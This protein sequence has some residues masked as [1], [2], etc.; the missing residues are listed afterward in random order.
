[1]N[2]KPVSIPVVLQ[3]GFRPFF[4]AAGIYAVIAMLAWMLFY[5]QPGSLGFL[6]YSPLHWH[7]HE[8]IFGYAMAVVSG[9][10]L[11]AIRNW[12]GMQTVNGWLLA[13]LLGCWLLA[14]LSFFSEML[15]ASA[16]FDTLFLGGLTVAASVPIIKAKN[17]NNISILAKLL[18]LLLANV[19]FYLGALGL[20]YRGGLHVGIYAGFYLVLALVFMM[21]RRVIPFFIQQGVDRPVTPRNSKWLDLSSMVLF[22]AFAILDIFGLYPA[23]LAVIAIALFAIHLVRMA[24]WYTQQIWRRPMLWVLY[25]AYACLVFGFLLKA[26][27]IW[28][29]VPPSIALHSFA[30][31]GIGMLTLGMMSRVTIGHT[32]RQMSSPPV[33]VWLVFLLI[34]LAW[35]TRVLAV[36]L[37][38]ADVSLW[39]FMSQL[40]WIAAFCLFILV[41]SPMLLRPRVDGKPG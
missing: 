23:A 4:L 9:F 39:I 27:S 2:D 38:P 37:L 20:I 31:A 12:T 16:I 32:G 28:S 18:L 8:M 24:G 13:L 1:M 7:A 10:L 19:V 36:L 6:A 5:Q 41:F 33:L 35:V 30:L 21:A 15:W 25:L 11:T 40:L 17:W 3:M 22:L 14:R 26:L 29:D 34:L